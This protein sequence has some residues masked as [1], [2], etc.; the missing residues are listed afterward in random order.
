MTVTAEDPVQ[1][2]T[3]DGGAVL[4]VSGNTKQWVD[5]DPAWPSTAGTGFKVPRSDLRALTRPNRSSANDLGPLPPLPPERGN[6]F[7]CWIKTLDTPQFFGS[8]QSLTVL[9]QAGYLFGTGLQVRPR[10]GTNLIE[11]VVGWVADSFGTVLG[12][13]FGTTRINDG[14]VHHIAVVRGRTPTNESYA[15]V[16]ADGK[17]EGTAIIANLA[18]DGNLR[19]GVAGQFSFGNMGAGEV[20]HIAVYDY[21]LTDLQIAAI[22]AAGTLNET[23]RPSRYVFTEDG[24]WNPM[25]APKT[26]ETNP[27]AVYGDPLLKAWYGTEWYPYFPPAPIP[28]RISQAFG[29]RWS[30]EGLIQATKSLRW[31]VAAA[32]V[33][34]ASP[35][36]REATDSDSWRSSD[37][38]KDGYVY[39]G[40]YSTNGNYRGCWFLGTSNPFPD[41]RGKQYVITSATVRMRRTTSGGDGGNSAV[42]CGTHQYTSRPAGAPTISNAQNVGT[43]AWGGETKEMPIPI[44]WARDLIEGDIR[45]FGLYRSTGSPYLRTEGTTNY[46][47]DGRVTINFRAP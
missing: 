32:E 24:R 3:L 27:P 16:Y 14:E 2:V 12:S 10:D 4:Y 39:Q 13:V 25:I 28:G 47:L 29:L 22:H 26:V 15:T 20:A 41:L 6:T 17:P 11:G 34:P 46:A 36:R 8:P 7:S 1:G 40:E 43:L 23:Y 19:Q 44:S 37:D 5:D 30:V 21:P 18:A 31:S 38:W 33:L 42:Y 35:Q 9:F 45:G